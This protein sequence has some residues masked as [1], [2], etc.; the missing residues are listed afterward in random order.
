MV[1]H[2]LDALGLSHNNPVQIL[3]DNDNKKDRSDD[4]FP[5]LSGVIASNAPG[6]TREPG[7]LITLGS[8]GK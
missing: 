2:S 6:A 4:G 7:A 3:S 5:S 1:K 8:F